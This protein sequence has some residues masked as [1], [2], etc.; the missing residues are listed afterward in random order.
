MAKSAHAMSDRELL[1]IIHAEIGSVNKRLDTVE[2]SVTEWKK[3]TTGSLTELERGVSFIEAEFEDMKG[4]LFT[5]EQRIAELEA[6]I[7]GRLTDLGN[8]SRRNNIILHNVQ[9]KAEGEDCIKFVQD[10]IKETMNKEVEIE[11]AH[12]TPAFRQDPSKTRIIH[13][14]CLRRKDRDYL[15]TEGRKA[16]KAYTQPNGRKVF[17]TDDL[18]PQTR[19]EDRKLREKARSLRE[20]GYVAVIPF[21]VPRVL[22]YKRKDSPNSP[23]TTIHPNQ[24]GARAKV[25]G[26]GTQVGEDQTSADPQRQARQQTTPGENIRQTR[27][28]ADKSREREASSSPGPSIPRASERQT[29]WQS[30]KRRGSRRAK[31]K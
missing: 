30:P 19:E 9:E 13:A 20:E 12:R 25:R 3:E 4:T 16:L 26:G 27:S 28:T 11:A 14:K 1:E 17:I 6:H 18:E 24:H 7:E 31:T 2:Q 23:W 5:F 8:R 21:K 22:I 15:L 29:T 10:F